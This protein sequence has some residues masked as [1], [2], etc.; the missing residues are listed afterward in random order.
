MKKR[1]QH[2][3]HA[4]AAGV[5]ALGLS[6]ASLAATAP[7]AAF[8]T[9]QEGCDKFCTF[10]VVPYTRG[11]ERM[12]PVA[13]ILAE[14]EHSGIFGEGELTAWRDQHPDVDHVNE[15]FAACP[16]VEIG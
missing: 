14:E 13:D 6:H 5:L 11:H 8:L 3:L 9:V 1:S 16:D 7:A 4:L 2:L 15:E 10:C 12:R